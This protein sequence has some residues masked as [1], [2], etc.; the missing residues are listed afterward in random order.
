MAL[1]R[2]FRRFRG[3]TLIELLVVIAIIAILIGLLLPAVQKVR[4]AANRISCANNLHQ[5]GLAFHNFH[6]THN[7]LP[8]A[9]CA[10]GKPFSGGPWF[11][12]QSPQFS[13]GWGEGTNWSIYILPY[14]E[15][16]NVFDQLTFYGDSG[17]TNQSTSPITATY[18]GVT[19]SS[20]AWNNVTLINS[21][22][23]KLYRCPSDPK[24]NMIRNDSNVRD[25]TGN[26][27]LLVNRNSYVAIAGAVNDI[28]GSGQFRETRNTDSS[29]WTIGWGITAWGGM[30]VPDNGSVKFAS[31][32]DGLSNTMM[33]S[34]Q[35]DQLTAIQP[36][37]NQ[38][39]ND[40]WSV[41]STGGGLFR[42]HSS[43]VDATST[44]NPP[45]AWMDGRGQTFTTLRYK[46]NQKHPN[47]GNTYWPCQTSVGGIGV[48]VCGGSQG[49][50]GSGWNSE[51]ANVPLVSAHPGG[52]NAL[53]GD[54]SVH[55]LSDATDLLTLAELATRDDGLVIRTEI[56]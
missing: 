14:I 12:G 30:I 18:N 56:P 38:I 10:D 46:I 33:I 40:E 26:E 50:P 19:Y 17:W 15:Q 25:S 44:V 39:V 45:S 35:S 9:G 5:M 42:G 47:G 8:S 41:T 21:V 27:A 1:L 53:F 51:G 3:F 4:E 52:V 22:N 7:F 13:P 28:D 6:D 32:K 43:G 20:S 29:S 24:P 36:W 23:L 34:E 55:F 11:D 54:G 31:V 37:D 16:G 48:G 2:A 49:S